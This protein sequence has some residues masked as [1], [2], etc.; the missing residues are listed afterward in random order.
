MPAGRHSSPIL[1]TLTW[2]SLRSSKPM[3]GRHPSDL[4]GTRTGSRRPAYPPTPNRIQSL[5]RWRGHSQDVTA[6][7]LTCVGKS[8]RCTFDHFPHSLL[9]PSPL[10]QTSQKSGPQ[11]EREQNRCCAHRYAFLP[12]LGL[13]LGWQNPPPSLTFLVCHSAIPRAYPRREASRG[14]RRGPSLLRSTHLATW[15]VA[16]EG[17]SPSA[18]HTWGG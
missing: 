4:C 5:Y 12:P 18:L 8:W 9:F 6:G 3:S 11:R 10:F 17:P 1:G 13:G 16:K 7:V 15:R 14:G 2:H